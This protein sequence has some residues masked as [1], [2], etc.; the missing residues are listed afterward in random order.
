M[1]RAGRRLL[2]S[3]WFAVG[4]GVVIATGAILYTPHA[5]LNFNRAIQVHQCT[6]AE[7]GQA[8]PEGGASLMPPGLGGGEPIPSP[9]PPAPL[10]GMT[11]SYQVVQSSQDQ[12]IMQITIHS[13]HS[14]G[15]WKLSFV[16]PG[17]T[18]VYVPDARWQ[19]S[20]S[21]DGGTVSNYYGGTD[22]AGYAPI[23][24]HQPAGNGGNGDTVEFAVHGTGKASAP[25]HC[26][27]NGNAC[28]IRLSPHTEASWPGSG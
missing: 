9:S 4:A 28:T 19:Q 14:L 17:A 22:S 25:V 1:K 10:A 24:G 15:S 3:P 21:D 6:Q 7:C 11:F 27:Y 26:L 5:N 8:V 12:F 2:V 20:G 16:I 23:S 13:T 18:A